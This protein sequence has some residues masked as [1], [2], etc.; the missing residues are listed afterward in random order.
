MSDVRPVDLKAAYT[1]P[2]ISLVIFVNGSPAHGR[3]IRGKSGFQEEF[4]QFLS[5]TVADG[6][7]IDEDYGIPSSLFKLI[8]D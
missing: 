8:A 4:V 3:S 1:D 7:S 6:T 5:Y 2:S